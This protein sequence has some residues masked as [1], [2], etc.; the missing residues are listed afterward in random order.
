MGAASFGFKAYWVNRARMP[1]EYTEHPP[2]Q[3]VTDL[4]ALVTQN[5]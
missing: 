1:D 2:V 4:S 5:F 3:A